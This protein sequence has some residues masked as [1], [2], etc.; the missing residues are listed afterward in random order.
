MFVSNT[1]L[2]SFATPSA[3]WGRITGWALVDNAT[4]GAGNVKAAGELMPAQWIN[5]TDVV[6]IK[7]GVLRVMVL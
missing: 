1:S 5:A 7:A 6:Q 2:I 4:I 3:A